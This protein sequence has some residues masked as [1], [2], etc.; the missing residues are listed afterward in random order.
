MHGDPPHELARGPA[1]AGHSD[2]GAESDLT[3]SDDQGGAVNAARIA[4]VDLPTFPG[5]ASCPFSTAGGMALSFFGHE[6]QPHRTRKMKGYGHLLRW[7]RPAHA[8]NPVQDG[9]KR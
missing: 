5:Q 3:G 9:Q 4:R 6:D 7:R 8:I 2:V 1:V